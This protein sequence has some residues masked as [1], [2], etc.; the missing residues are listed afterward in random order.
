MEKKQ[1]EVEKQKEME[2]KREFEKS[3]FSN[4]QFEEM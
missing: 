3:K 4:G 1:K 2:K